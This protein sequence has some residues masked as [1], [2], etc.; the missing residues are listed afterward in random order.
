[1]GTPGRL[2]DHIESNPDVRK[3]LQ[4]VK[5]LVL[6]EADQLLDMGFRKSLDG[7]IKVLPQQRQTLLFSATVPA[8][9]HSMS[10]IALKKDHVF[11]DTVGEEDEETH[12]KVKQEYLIVPLEKQ[13]STIY[14]LLTE[15]ASQEPKFKVRLQL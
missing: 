15:H 8:Q 13:L 14:A 1:V 11:I 4:N 9:V 6:D 12:A 10:Q 3:Q 2:L 7:I 5:V